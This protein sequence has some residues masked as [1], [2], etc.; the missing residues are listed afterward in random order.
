MLFFLKHVFPCFHYST[1]NT[2]CWEKILLYLQVDG[3]FRR[4]AFGNPFLDFSSDGPWLF[5]VGARCVASTN[6]RLAVCSFSFSGI[7]Q[8]VILRCSAYTRRVG[9]TI[10]LEIQLG[11]YSTPLLSSLYFLA[12]RLVPCLTYC[13][14]AAEEQTLE[15]QN[16]NRA[17]E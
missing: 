9:K 5:L 6:R 11:T 15:Q 4:K 17:Y 10:P 14:P 2:Y 3:I 12:L 13:G 7:G 16:Y 8:R 1:T